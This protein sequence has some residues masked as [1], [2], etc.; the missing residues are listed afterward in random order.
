MNKLLT[1]FKLTALGGLLVLLPVLLFVLLLMEIVQMVVGLATPIAGM[2]PAGTFDDA[3]SPVVLAVTLLAGASLLIGI[4]M[5]SSAAQ[6]LGNWIQEKT[7]NKLPIYR[8]VRTLVSGLVGAE[9]KGSFKPALFDAGNGQREIIYLVEDLGDGGFTA[10]FPHAPTGFAG[11]VKIVAKDRIA[12]LDA[13]LGDV[14]L[15]MNH[16]GLG[17]GKLLKTKG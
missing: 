12:P 2:F 7:L 9:K 4:A 16:M 15:V 13:S 6:R 1:F 5:R 17:A 11:P 3:K 14:S 8:F 10:L